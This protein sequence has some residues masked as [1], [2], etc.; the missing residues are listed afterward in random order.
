MG[1]EALGVNP[2]AVQDF[3]Q[4]QLRQ[5]HMLSTLFGRTLIENALPP[6]PQLKQRDPSVGK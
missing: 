6:M 4:E 5:L 2:A 1:L 3:Q